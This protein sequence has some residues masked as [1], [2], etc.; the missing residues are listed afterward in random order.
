M[1]DDQ[2]GPFAV[3][4]GPHRFDRGALYDGRELASLHGREAAARVALRFAEIWERAHD[5]SPA[6]LGLLARADRPILAG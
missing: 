5:I 6:V 3:L 1:F 2:G 4:I